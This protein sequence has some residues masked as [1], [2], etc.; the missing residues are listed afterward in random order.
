[1]TRPHMIALLLLLLLAAVLFLRPREQELR[2]DPT[3]AAQVEPC[4]RLDYRTPGYRHPW[5]PIEDPDKD[6]R[7]Y[8]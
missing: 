5:E 7:S 4:P 8:A 3:P 2:I 6:P 1:M